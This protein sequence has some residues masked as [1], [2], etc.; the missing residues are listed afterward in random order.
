MFL[1][2]QIWSHLHKLT[3]YCNYILYKICYM[4][5]TTK[6]I[7]PGCKASVLTYCHW[8]SSPCILHCA[9]VCPHNVTL[10]H[11]WVNGEHCLVGAYNSIHNSLGLLVGSI[12][13]YHNSILPP[14]DSGSRSTSGDASEGVWWSIESE[15]SYVRWTCM[16]K[17]QWTC[18]WEYCFNGDVKSSQNQS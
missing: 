14:G 17:I 1:Y 16:V 4:L 10:T 7:M 9:V 8:W 12:E 6:A 5:V 11:W 18:I 3:I 2:H 13:S 15:T